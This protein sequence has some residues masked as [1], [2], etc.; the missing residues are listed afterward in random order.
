M[1]LQEISNNIWENVITNCDNLFKR[2]GMKKIIFC[3]PG[4]TF[5]D[6]FLKSWTELVQYSKHVEITLINR[7]SSNVYY[8]RNLCLGGD[9]LAGIHQKPF[10]GKLD[11]DYLMWIDS[12]MVFT[13]QQVER[14]IAILEGYKEV[15]IISGIYP[16]E[17]KIDFATVV[18]WDLDF[19][20]KYGR[21]QFL[22]KHDLDFYKDQIIEV[23]Y[24][25]FGFILI[26]KGVVESMEYPWFRPIWEEF[27]LPDGTHIKDY[28]SEDVGF[29][30]TAISLGHKIFVDPSLI[31]GHEK[32]Q[33]LR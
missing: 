6:N 21:F 10:Q 29:C 33:V 17:N 16:M 9:N 3:I 22:T 13:Y 20:R 26:K 30:R 28:T 27:D 7:Y 24:T 32:S 14:L 12:D 1:S 4:R 2:C 31:I 8:A 11:Y 18:N 25:G 19:F 23:A 5:S 15:N